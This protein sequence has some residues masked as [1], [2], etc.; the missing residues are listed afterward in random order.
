MSLERISGPCKHRVGDAMDACGQ[1]V[2]CRI[3]PKPPEFH[4]ASRIHDFSRFTVRAV[5]IYPSATPEQK[6]RKFGR[7][8]YRLELIN[9]MKMRLLGLCVLVVFAI[10]P[11]RAYAEKVKTNQPAKL[12]AHPGERSKVILK[13]KEGQSMTV[14]TKEGRWVKVRVLGRTGFVPRSK[15]DMADDGELARNTRRRPFVDGRSTRR[16]FD[17]QEAPEDRIGADATEPSA[18]T[19]DDEEDEDRRKKVRASDNDDDEG[20]RTA[21]SPR[22]SG[23]DREGDDR[24]VPSRAASGDGD[25]DE[26]GAREPERLTARVRTKSKIYAERD[27]SSEVAFTARPS[28]ELY[29]SETKGSWTLVESADG[30]V[31]WI[32]TASLAVKESSPRDGSLRRSIEVKGGL[33]V[34]FI[35]QSM[36]TIGTTLTGADQVPDVYDIGTAA[37]TVDLGA[38]VL[39]PLGGKYLA[40]GELLFGTSKTLFGGVNYKSTT[41]GLTIMDVALRGV[42]AYPTRS[43]GGMQILAR[44]GL[45]YRAYMV[46]DYGDVMKN[47]AKIPQETLIAPT[48]GAAVA[49]PKLTKSIGLEVSLDTILI[50]SSVTQT[51]GLEDGATPSMKSVR[52]GLDAVYHWKTNLD[53]QGFYHLDYASYDFGTPNMGAAMQS[54]RGHTGT[55]VSRTD[56]VHVVSIGVAKGF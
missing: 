24:E 33:G 21:G 29:P 42:F 13:L 16:G 54:T 50:G 14:L 44:L 53:L 40:G 8:A 52:L 5:L 34:A 4:A 15:L 11:S 51:A 9:T 31:G 19:E 35:Q 17:S 1:R 28:E 56:M 43:L 32:P 26:P 47:P 49:F 27:K 12:L 39:A 38:R 23:G 41:T 6:D 22:R 55:N 25:G 7:L 2:R 36:R 45:R 18:R 20:G 48:L 30:D 10:G 3:V 37:A 46:S